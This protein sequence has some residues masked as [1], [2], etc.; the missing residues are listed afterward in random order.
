MEFA[1]K[2]KQPDQI[3]KQLRLI[4]K[5]RNDR[6]IF[7]IGSYYKGF[8]YNLK[9]LWI[10]RRTKKKFGNDRSNKRLSEQNVTTRLLK[11]R[12]YILKKDL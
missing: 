6:L 1:A 8:H 3:K 2:I 10:Y 7:K 4:E 12:R 5:F 11:Q 9:I